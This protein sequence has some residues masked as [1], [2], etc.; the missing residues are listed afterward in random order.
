MG[1]YMIRFT[2]LNAGPVLNQAL[3]GTAALSLLFSLLL[4]IGIILYS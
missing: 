2:W 1:L 3:A 4:S